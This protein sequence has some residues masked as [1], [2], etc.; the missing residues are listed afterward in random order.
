MPP[1]ASAELAARATKWY[2]EDTGDLGLGLP[3]ALPKATDAVPA[4]SAAHPRRDHEVVQ[5]GHEQERPDHRDLRDQQATE[6]GVRE[7]AVLVRGGEAGDGEQRERAPA[8]RPPAAADPRQHQGPLARRQPPPIGNRDRDDGDAAADPDTR[9][10]HVQGVDQQIHCLPGAGSGGVGDAEVG[11]YERLELG[12][13]RRR[14]ELGERAPDQA[15]VDRADDLLVAARELDERARPH[16]PH[17][18]PGDL[19]REP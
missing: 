3:D 10:E 6:P 16:P 18:H 9:C 7:A 13:A 8:D 12:G 1:G 17:A 15:E 11:P 4:L 2:L 5:P 14:A 19:R